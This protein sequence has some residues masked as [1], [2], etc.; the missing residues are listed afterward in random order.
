V[1]EVDVLVDDVTE[2]VNANPLFRAELQNQALRRILQE[3]DVEIVFLRRENALLRGS[4]PDKEGERIK[5]IHKTDV[6]ADGEIRT[7]KVE[8]NQ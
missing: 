8:V 5:W 6:D 4:D 7:S 2:L 1:A 3:K